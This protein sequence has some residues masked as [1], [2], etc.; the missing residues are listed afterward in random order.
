MSEEKLARQYQT[1]ADAIETEGL[2]YALTDGGYITP[3]MT[4]DPEL[5]QAIKDARNAC[6]EIKRIVGP[7]LP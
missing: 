2:G 6:D 7:Y 4:D 1:I 3:D 5:K